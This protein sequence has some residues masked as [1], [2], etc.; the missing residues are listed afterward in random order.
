MAEQNKPLIPTQVPTVRT[1][2]QMQAH[3]NQLMVWL[4]SLLAVF[5]GSALRWG[6]LGALVL[7]MFREQIGGLIDRMARHLFP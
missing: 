7:I 2:L 1:P 6:I 3:R 5:G 4:L